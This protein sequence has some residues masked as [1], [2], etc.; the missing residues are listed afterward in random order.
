MQVCHLHNKMITPHLLQL[1]S[2]SDEKKGVWVASSMSVQTRLFIHFIQALFVYFL[3]LSL[4]L[5][6]SFLYFFVCLRLLFLFLGMSFSMSMS[7][8]FLLSGSVFV[9]VYAFFYIFRDCLCLCLCLCE[10]LSFS[11]QTGSDLHT[12]CYINDKGDK[13][14]KFL[15]KAK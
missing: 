10:K 5:L 12:A 3:D 7:F 1:F 15:A 9:F 14:K 13:V 11:F 2:P 8:F 6:L 4:S